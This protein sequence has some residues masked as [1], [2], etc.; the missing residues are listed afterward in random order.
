MAK[1][2]DGDGGNSGSWPGFLSELTKNFLILRDIFGYALPGAVFLAIG[3]FC[4]RFSLRDVQYFFEPYK[5]PAWLGLTLG[6]VA[7]Y[8]AGHVMAQLAYLPDNWKAWRRMMK[9][10]ADASADADGK[11]KAAVEE[12]TECKSLD[13][14]L[15]EI[16]ESHPA[17][18]TELDRQST[19]SQFR[20]G[21][22]AAMLLGFV[23]FYLIRVLLPIGILVGI[24]GAVQ[25]LVFWVT[26]TAHIDD[27]KCDTIA[28]GEKVLNVEKTPPS[29]HS[30][31][32]PH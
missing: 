7:C 10:K 4:R 9:A 2:D 6:L 20:G 16:R 23:V 1:S 22:G 24:A 21:V 30:K 28:A 15:I 12:K 29:A 26:G 19:I 13:P 25:I 27:L 11:P 5:I 17:L 18:L 3:L 8:T 31:N 14:V 32:Q